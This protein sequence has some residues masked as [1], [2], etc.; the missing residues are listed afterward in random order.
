MSEDKYT[1]KIDES[2]NDKEKRKFLD[3][4][5]SSA[6]QRHV[7][8]HMQIYGFPTLSCEEIFQYIIAA[9]YYN[10]KTVTYNTP[11]GTI[12]FNAKVGAPND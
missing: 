3:R 9:G 12:T 4:L 10:D 6:L 8:T 11:L 2:P 1:A 5:V 7:E